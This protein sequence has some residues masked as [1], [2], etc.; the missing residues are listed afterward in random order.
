MD[1]NERVLR[2][3]EQRRRWKLN[4]PAKVAAAKKHYRDTPAAKAK[5]A[6]RDKVRY[7]T[8]PSYRAAK[9]ARNRRDGK[10]H[11]KQRT[12]RDKVWR[13]THPERHREGKRIR[14]H[15]QA[16]GL[17]DCYVREQLSKRST[18]SAAAWPQEFVDL[19]RANMQLKR[20]T[21]RGTK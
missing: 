5:A 13:K 17:Q 15:A 6:A 3:R 12:E 10:A 16:M 14:A 21:K 7:A 2:A 20:T 11:R 1:A 9:Q 4:N 8:D 18:I 19:Y